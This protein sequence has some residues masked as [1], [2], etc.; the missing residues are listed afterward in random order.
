MNVT[1]PWPPSILSP[2][3]RAHWSRKAIA[4][5]K[6]RRDCAYIAMG[7]GVRALGWPGMAVGLVFCPPDQRPR[8]LDNML[9]AMKSGLDGLRD[10]TGVDDSKWSLTIARGGAVK[11]GHVLVSVAPN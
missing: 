4:A 11:G 1:L 5:A 7:A 8:D 10:A 2:N 6:H 9:A 3:A